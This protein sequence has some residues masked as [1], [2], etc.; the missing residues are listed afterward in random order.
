MSTITL[1]SRSADNTGFAHTVGDALLAPLEFCGRSWNSLSINEDS[2]CLEKIALVAR[3]VILG[4]LLSIAT[5]LAFIPGAVGSLIKSI[6]D[7]PVKE[8]WTLTLDE[9]LKK[10]CRENGIDNPNADTS[11]IERL[12]IQRCAGNRLPI[13]SP[14]SEYSFDSAFWSV[15]AFRLEPSER[16]FASKVIVLNTTGYGLLITRFFNNLLH[17]FFPPLTGDEEAI[18]MKELPDLILGV[19]REP[20]NDQNKDLLLDMIFSA[21]QF[22]VAI[23]EDLERMV[24]HKN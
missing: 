24:I 5:A 6:S 21:N 9:Q 7:D 17:C 16:D 4:A 11:V 15:G 1:N 20:S 22:T 13:G 14:F 12:V 23:S 19:E 8:T 18:A 3:N 2:E 10:H